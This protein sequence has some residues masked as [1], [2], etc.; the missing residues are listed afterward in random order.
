VPDHVPPLQEPACCGLLLQAS[1]PQTKALA[2]AQLALHLCVQ[3][4]QL[5]C[6][7]AGHKVCRVKAWDA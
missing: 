7:F 6:G 2:Q 5:L 4:M 3:Y 1:E